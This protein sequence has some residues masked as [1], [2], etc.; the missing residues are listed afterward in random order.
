[1]KSLSLL[2]YF[3]YNDGEQNYLTNILYSPFILPSNIEKVHPQKNTLSFYLL[4]GK[5]I[6]AHIQRYDGQVLY[7]TYHACLSIS[8]QKLVSELS[9]TQTDQSLLL[10]QREEDSSV[11]L[12]VSKDFA[13][14]E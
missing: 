7:A 12:R 6:Q 14:G 11:F 4:R 8:R 9:R 5:S 13:F 10:W 1:M 3:I 2:F